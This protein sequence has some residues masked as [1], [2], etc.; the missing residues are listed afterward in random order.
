MDMEPENVHCTFSYWMWVGVSPYSNVMLVNMSGET[1]VALSLN[2]IFAVKAT[3]SSSHEGMSQ[4][5]V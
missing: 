2:T 3:L 4:Q 5:N 1:K